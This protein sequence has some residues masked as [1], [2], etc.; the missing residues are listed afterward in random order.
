MIDN[1]RNS[2]QVREDIE[3]RRKR[4]N[5]RLNLI[6][7]GLVLIAGIIA[8]FT[9]GGDSSW[10]TKGIVLLVVIAWVTFRLVGQL[11]RSRRG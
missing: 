4:I 11:R 1:E 5:K 9:M 2:L 3:V 7:I 10:R 8:V 6:S